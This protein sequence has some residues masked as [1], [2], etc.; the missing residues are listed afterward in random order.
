MNS[1]PLDNRCFIYGISNKMFI[2]D[3]SNFYNLDTN[4]FNTSFSQ[5]NT[6]PSSFR[7]S[8]MMNPHK[9]EKP[10]KKKN[11]Q[12]KPK[13]NKSCTDILMCNEYD[14][15][16]TPAANPSTATVSAAT[17]YSEVS[18]DSSD[19]LL[20]TK[21]FILNERTTESDSNFHYLNNNEL[22]SS[23]S[24][25]TQELES[26]LK[27]RRQMIESRSKLF[28]EVTIKIKD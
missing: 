11:S 4:H 27:E 6:I 20:K 14:A 26:K 2:D 3:L 8:S 13:L 1:L 22:I 7:P 5:I 23:T 15:I 21:S 19:N 12:K 16:E 17:S 24:I 28:D 18:N 25:L 10:V 9:N